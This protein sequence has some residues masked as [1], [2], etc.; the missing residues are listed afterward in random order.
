M[1]TK[2]E[3][4]NI[5]II[6]DTHQCDTS[7]VDPDDNWSRADTD[8]S[9][10]IEYIKIVDDKDYND[11]VVPFKIDS[12]KNYFLL[13]VVYST[14]NSFGHDG[15]QI[16]FIELYSDLELAEQNRKEIEEHNH[17]FSDTYH[18]SKKN[19]LKITNQAGKTYQC[20]C[21]WIGYFERVEDVRIDTVRVLE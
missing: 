21:C 3:F 6:D 15:G 18:S 4:T 16:S 9:H 2:P 10:S 17:N 12:Q 5:R 11:L 14:G 20:Y 19:E 1:S 13:S 8:T 7:E